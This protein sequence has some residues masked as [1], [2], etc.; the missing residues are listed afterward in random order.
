[1]RNRITACSLAFG[2]ALSGANAQTLLSTTRVSAFGDWDG[3]YTL[4]EVAIATSKFTPDI[5][6][7]WITFIGVYHAVS[8]DGITFGP[9]QPLPGIVGDPTAAFSRVDGTLWLGGLTSAPQGMGV[10]RKLPGQ[11]VESSVQVVTG[12]AAGGFV[13]KPLMAVGPR[14]PAWGIGEHMVAGWTRFPSSTALL[15]FMQAR[16]STGVTPGGTWT[17]SDPIYPVSRTSVTPGD[18]G[19]AGQGVC[20]AIVAV[21]PNAGRLIVA[22]H[23][24]DDTL[25][26]HNPNPPVLMWSDNGGEPIGGQSSWDY[27]QT[28]TGSQGSAAPPRPGELAVA[29]FVGDPTPVDIRGIYEGDHPVGVVDVNN[30]SVCVDPRNGNLV[31]AAFAGKPTNSSSGATYL[32]IAQSINGGATFAPDRTIIIG[33]SNLVLPSGQPIG[34]SVLFMPAIAVD[35]WGSVNILFYRH[36]PDGM[37]EDVQAMY[38]R[39]PAADYTAAGLPTLSAPTLELAPAFDSRKTFGWVGDYNMIDVRGCLAVAGFVSGHENWPS[40]FEGMRA[41]IYVSRINLC[42]PTDN[43]ADLDGNG[44]VNVADANLFFGYY[45]TGDARADMTGEGCVAMPDV[46]NFLQR[47][48]CGCNP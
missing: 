42:A 2:L 14:P 17:W 40:A 30:P 35:Q 45:G 33:P 23:P 27:A 1:M 16:V 31:Y 21:G 39:V 32:I 37:R 46:T 7:S 25:G 5:A 47:L 13:D 38:A 29:H 19:D 11:P 43:L 15:G 22:H 12:S 34:Q 9:E 18:A 10:C 41:Q 6:V 24:P 36:A 8:T 20:P 48:S 26:T 44:V 4:G 3:R 28:S